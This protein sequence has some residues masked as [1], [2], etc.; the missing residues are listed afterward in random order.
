MAYMSIEL[1]DGA[2]GDIE[3]ALIRAGFGRLESAVLMEHIIGSSGS[4][5]IRTNKLGRAGINPAVLLQKL[6]AIG[7][8]VRWTGEST[9]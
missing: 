2:V 1:R 6:K 9:A 3:A 4:I 7:L 8:V 5:C